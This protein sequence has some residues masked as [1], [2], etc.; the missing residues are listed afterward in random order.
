MPTEEQLSREA[1]KILAKYGVIAD[2]EISDKDAQLRAQERR[3]KYY[4]NTKKMLEIYRKTK[5]SIAYKIAQAAEPD[6]KTTDIFTHNIDKLSQEFHNCY[7]DDKNTNYMMQSTAI[8]NKLI[9]RIDESLECLKNMP[10]H[11][12]MYYQ[13]LYYT[14]ISDEFMDLKL[15]MDKVLNKLN[16]SK[17]TYYTEKN[18]AIDELSLIIWGSGSKELLV[19]TEVII[20]TDS[21][22]HRHKKTCKKQKS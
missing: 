18:K 5:W 4:Q 14:Y 12:E 10:A 6:I 21:F 15:N 8:S 2:R 17:S 22:Q 9:K 11:G 1:M 16:I 19:W 13:L 3:S 7:Y 20:A